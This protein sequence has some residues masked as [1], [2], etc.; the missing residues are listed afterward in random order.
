MFRYKIDEDVFV[1]HTSGGP[2]L[3][4]A[5]TIATSIHLSG[6]VRSVGVSSPGNPTVTYQG[7]IWLILI[8]GSY[9]DPETSAVIDAWLV[10]YMTTNDI[11]GW[12]I[13]EGNYTGVITAQDVA[14]GLKDVGKDVV[15][16]EYSD[17]ETTTTETATTI[18]LT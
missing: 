8:K 10:Y 7:T 13:Y 9:V 1:P 18:T 4:V 6:E 12:P 15:L 11:D 5:E 16:M 3:T 2:D 17:F 14:Q